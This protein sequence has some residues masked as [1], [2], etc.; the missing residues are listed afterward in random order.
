MR[1]PRFPASTYSSAAFETNSFERVLGVLV[2]LAAD[3]D[4]LGQVPDAQTDPLGRHARDG[5]GSL[6]GG[7]V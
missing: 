7:D 6:G 1:S 4:G 5:R 2:G 3:E